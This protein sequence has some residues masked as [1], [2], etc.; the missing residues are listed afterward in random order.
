ME[1]VS[2]IDNVAGC[3]GEGLGL[4]SPM[5]HRGNKLKMKK[6]MLANNSC[7]SPGSTPWELYF[8]ISH[9]QFFLQF[10]PLFFTSAL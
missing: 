6:G 7:L 2:S 1:Q 3:E 4:L 10:F 8:L 9:L 5:F